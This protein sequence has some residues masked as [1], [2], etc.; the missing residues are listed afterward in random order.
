MS[1]A[2]RN[3]PPLGV[4]FSALQV[5]SDTR[6]LVFRTAEKVF[7]RPNTALKLSCFF[8]PNEKKKK[9]KSAAAAAAAAE[10]ALTNA[11][12]PQT[13]RAVLAPRFRIQLTHKHFFGGDETMRATVRARY[14]VSKRFLKASSHLKKRFPL[15][16]STSLNLR[17]DCI[18]K[19]HAA[20]GSGSA[21]PTFAIQTP[22]LTA[23]AELSHK[24]LA[25][26]STQ[27]FQ[28]RVGYELNENELYVT[29]RE[30]RISMRISSSGKWHM[31][32]DL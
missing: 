26:T 11:T 23:R 27:D 13:D 8:E 10:S 15:G 25:G 22:E 6:T 28:I 4:C 21:V 19:L 31:L 18:A 16:G 1:G 30:N 17:G 9:D 20:E 7:L 29:A 14:D 12:A 32:Y 24:I 5:D 3:G 2:S